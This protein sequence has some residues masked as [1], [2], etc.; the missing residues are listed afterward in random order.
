MH[1]PRPTTA[2]RPIRSRQQQWAIAGAAWL[3]RHGFRPNQISA[4]SVLFAALAGGCALLLPHVAHVGGRAALMLGAALAIQLRLLCNLF[5]GM[6]AIE[7]GQASPAGAVWNELPDRLA[8][9]LILVPYGYAISVVS[10][11]AELGWLAGLLALLTAYTRVLG[12]SLGLAQDF[13]G[14]MAKHHRM[15]VLT[16]GW[17][18]S[19]I[20]LA[21]GGAG[22]VLLV[23]LLVIVG[24]SALT[25]VR[26]TGQ[27]VRTLDRGGQ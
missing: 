21:L 15:A 9:P 18:S 26:R 24:G 20:E 3:A 11:G 8:D 25:V 10:W 19:L 27:I 4:L 22:W 7:G 6:V 14:P 17:L 12:G 1:P 5:D 2:R 13:R 23:A 16:G